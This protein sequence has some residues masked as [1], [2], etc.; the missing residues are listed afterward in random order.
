VSDIID[1]DPMDKTLKDA[2]KAIKITD[3]FEERNQTRKV[4]IAIYFKLYDEQRMLKEKKKQA[5]NSNAFQIAQIKLDFVN[6]LLN[7]DGL[8]E[9]GERLVEKAAE[10]VGKRRPGDLSV[11]VDDVNQT[12]TVYQGASKQNANKFNR[13]DIVGRGTVTW[14]LLV[15]FAKC[16]GSLEGNTVAEIKKKNTSVNRII[17][18][19]HL[20]AAMDL[21]KSPIIEDRKG[22]M[23]FGSIRL[24]GSTSS[25][26]AMD[27]KIISIDDQGTEYLK[28]RGDNMPVLD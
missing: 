4:V 28:S 24:A 12:V 14:D 3:D 27:R 5:N 9:L 7:I 16:N 6:E 22:A 1:D 18:G 25:T 23:C 13:S 10:S 20:M 2:Y 11:T 17:L 19:E 26:D 15:A 21:D 8:K